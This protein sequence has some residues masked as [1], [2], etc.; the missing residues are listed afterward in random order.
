MAK[1]IAD[2]ER[3]GWRKRFHFHSHSTHTHTQIQSHRFDCNKRAQGIHEKFNEWFKRFVECMIVVLYDV[4]QCQLSLLCGCSI[5]SSLFTHKT[6]QRSSTL[7][8]FFYLLIVIYVGV[9]SFRHCGCG[10]S[11]IVDCLF[12]RKWI[13]MQCRPVFCHSQNGFDCILFFFLARAIYTIVILRS[14]Y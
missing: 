9:Y 1:V 14:T 4:W 7:N 11:F 12:V 2:Y 8:T 3:E 13:L 10:F 6:L 5:S